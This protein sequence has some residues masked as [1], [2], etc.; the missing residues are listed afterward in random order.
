M[1]LMNINGSVVA[2]T[3][4]SANGCYNLTGVIPSTCYRV[5]VVLPA[6]FDR[7]SP[8]GV[9]SD[10][11]ATG[12]SDCFTITSGDN[13]TVDAGVYQTA[14][15]AGSVWNDLNGNGIRENEAG[16]AG[17]SVVLVNASTGAFVA[18][19]ITNNTGYY[20]FTQ[21]TPA[22]GGYVVVVLLPNANWAFS[23]AA[24]GLIEIL[25]SDM[26][27]QNITAGS[28]NAIVLTAGQL[29]S[30]YS[31]AGAFLYSFIEGCVFNDT[32]ADGLRVAGE[33]GV[34]GV[35]ITLLD[36]N[37]ATVNTTSTNSSGC[38]RIDNVRPGV[39]Y[40]IQV[41]LPPNFDRFS[42]RAADSDVHE[43]LARDV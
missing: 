6:A 23:P 39:C 12:S 10:V 11:N 34:A 17:F 15:L 28:T 24:Q 22:N 21:L 19:A 35:L 7:F 41:T 16:V 20:L 9:D 4:T 38:Y 40:S 30:G 27:N 26:D 8:R 13:E 3:L 42:P 2:W 5:Q 36:N 14:S 29:T 1:T 31:D 37:T 33:V 25:D 43:A 32:S 18:S